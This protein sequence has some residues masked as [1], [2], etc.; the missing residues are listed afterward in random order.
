[1]AAHM[2]IDTSS[3]AHNQSSAKFFFVIARDVSV[4]E[5]S[6]IKHERSTSSSVTSTLLT[7]AFFGRCCSL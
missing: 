5:C 7:V 6:N 2:V 4:Q 3:M 1:M